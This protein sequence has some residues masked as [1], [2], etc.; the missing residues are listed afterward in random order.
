MACRSPRSEVVDWVWVAAAGG[1]WHSQR[2]L[3][4]RTGFNEEE[5]V[6]ALRFLVKYGFAESSFAEEERYRMITHAPSPSEAANLLRVVAS[7]PFEVFL[8]P[9]FPCKASQ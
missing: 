2:D 4:H 1:R 8:P 5:I 7:E 6:A 3:V 9:R